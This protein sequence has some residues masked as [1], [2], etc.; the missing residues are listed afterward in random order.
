VFVIG[1]ALTG[2]DGLVVLEFWCGGAGFAL[3]HIGPNVSPNI[4]SGAVLKIKVPIMTRPT[5]SDTE[6][7]RADPMQIMPSHAHDDVDWYT[8]GEA[9]RRMLGPTPGKTKR[10]RNHDVPAFFLSRRREHHT[11]AP[12]RKLN[13][14]LPMHRL[15]ILP[16]TNLIAP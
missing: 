4:I 14:W 11:R 2:G 7:F 16:E 5:V 3:E 13:Q 8:S 1:R 15:V 6:N 10:C 12:R 9:P